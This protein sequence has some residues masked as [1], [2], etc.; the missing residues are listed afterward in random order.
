MG[1]GTSTTFRKKRRN[2]GLCAFGGRSASYFIGAWGGAVDAYCAFVAVFGGAL[3]YGFPNTPRNHS[4]SINGCVSSTKTLNFSLAVRAD[5]L[6]LMIFF[7]IF[8]KFL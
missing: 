3:I 6:R 7:I 1:K 5:G 2:S 8:R 4:R